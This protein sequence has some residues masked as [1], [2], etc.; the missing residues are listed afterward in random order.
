MFYAFNLSD[1]HCFL[2]TWIP[3]LLQMNFI[4]IVIWMYC[5]IHGISMLCVV[6]MLT[7][8]VVSIDIGMHNKKKLLLII[9]WICKSTWVLL[10]HQIVMMGGILY[11]LIILWLW[12]AKRKL[13]LLGNGMKR[14]KGT[15]AIVMA[16]TPI[17]QLSIV[18]PFLIPICLLQAYTWTFLN[19]KL[20]WKSLPPCEI[21]VTH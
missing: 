9:L 20:T 7:M 10:I 13:W 16:T 2:W 12:I 8:M 19:G 4:F 21:S 15:S 14:R 11:C 1:L 3:L 5:T 6:C 18:F 17:S